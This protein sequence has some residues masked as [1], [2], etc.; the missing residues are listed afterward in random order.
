[1]GH[2]V[3]KRGYDA[4]TNTLTGEAATA[5]A[6][7]TVHVDGAIAPSFTTRSNPD[8]SFS[9]VLAGLASGDHSLRVGLNGT[10]LRSPPL[11]ITKA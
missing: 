10:S 2:T 5:N 8:R 11:K 7:V 1:M 9:V 3:R 6:S 4:A